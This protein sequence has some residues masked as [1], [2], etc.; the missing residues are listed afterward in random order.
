ML[1]V[2]SIDLPCPTAGCARVV[3]APRGI[4]SN[5]LEKHLAVGHALPQG[6][7][8]RLMHKLQFTFNPGPIPGTEVP[9]DLDTNIPVASNLSKEDERPFGDEFW[10]QFYDE[11]WNDGFWDTFWDMF[12]DMLETRDLDGP[13]RNA[14]NALR[15]FIL[16]TP[17]GPE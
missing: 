9:L 5:A 8:D 1:R 12:W 6:E 16:E 7:V 10:D 11:F 4:A 3:S 14:L 15:K 13:A 2:D 17:T